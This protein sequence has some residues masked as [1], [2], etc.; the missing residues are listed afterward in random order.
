MKAAQFDLTPEQIRAYELSLDGM[1]KAKRRL[2]RNIAY[3]PESPSAI[4]SEYRLELLNV[5]EGY[6]RAVLAQGDGR[7]RF[8][9]RS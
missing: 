8:R 3:K 7:R 2:K 5:I 1:K 6:M 4:D 9:N